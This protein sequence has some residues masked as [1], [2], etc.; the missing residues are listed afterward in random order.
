MDVLKL[1]L[2]S[3]L[4]ASVDLGRALGRVPRDVVWWAVRRLGI[5]EWLVRL[6]QSVCRGVGG[7]VGVGDGCGGEFGVGVGVHQ[8]SVL[9]PQLFVVVLEAL[10]GEFRAGCPWGLLCAGDLVVGAGS[11]E[12][13]LVG[14]RAWG[15]GWGG[16]LRVGVGEAGIMGSGIDL[17]VLKRSGGCPLW[18]LS[19]GCWGGWCDPV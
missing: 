15:R 7:G 13:L 6:V 5:D 14:V 11:M 4:M 12:E 9:G 16:G 19:G 3:S 2:T 18:C 17:D 8:G 10:S 1:T